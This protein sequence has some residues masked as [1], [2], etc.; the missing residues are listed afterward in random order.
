M[1]GT[2]K[3]ILVLL[4]IAS[5]PVCLA[6]CKESMAFQKLV[7][8]Q[9]VK[10]HDD[11]QDMVDNN[12]EYEDEDEDLFTRKD[13]ENLEDESHIEQSEPRLDDD[14]EDNGRT[15]ANASYDPN[16]LSNGDSELGNPDSDTDTD[17]GGA[18][19][20][21]SDEAK[22]YID[23]GNG[24]TD[25]S[26]GGS[27][28]GVNDD[29]GNAGGSDGQ[30]NDKNNPGIGGDGDSDLNNGTENGDDTENNNGD[31]DTDQNKVVYETVLA[32]GEAA[33]LTQMLGGAG[34]LYGTDADTLNKMKEYFPEEELA[35]IHVLWGNSDSGLGELDTTELNRLKTAEGL[36]EAC[37]LDAST[38]RESDKNALKEAGVT[39]CSA[40]TFESYEDIK[41]SV[42]TAASKLGTEQAT[43]MKEEY[44]DFCEEMEELVGEYD[45]ARYTLFVS[46]WDTAVNVIISYNGSSFRS[47]VGL[48]VANRMSS[49]PADEMWK[50]AGINNNYSS[51]NYYGGSLY[52]SGALSTSEPDRKYCYINQFF[53]TG[54]AGR[55]VTG[56]SYSIEQNQPV[57]LR[58]LGAAAYPA[59]ITET[60]DIQ[61]KLLRDKD[62]NSETQTGGMMTYFSQGYIPLFG[63]NYVR[64][65]IQGNY[66]VYVNPC[67]LGNWV[68]GSAESILE[69]FW[70]AWRIQGTCTEDQVK[71]AVKEFYSTFYRCGLTNDQLDAILAGPEE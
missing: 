24:V 5:L 70:S 68:D 42:Q 43:K 48:G 60:Q 54:S 19:T 22:G 14:M 58:G 61:A 29:E 20:T 50:L 1:K 46:D 3:K 40:L 57:L 27:G 16:G 18:L 33:I 10:E 67:G 8:D 55:N 59:L 44:M 26:E 36:P 7:Y 69:A 11:T 15:A 28:A 30:S 38:Y 34:A 62:W 53:V 37:L 21:S 64:A 17:R 9:N 23:N 45:S 25:E 56:A 13:Q 51:S 63:G 39:S 6:G 31:P 35:G 71:D 12:P 32:T 66:D 4:L 49:S 47:R 65:F 41:S 52:N 2:G